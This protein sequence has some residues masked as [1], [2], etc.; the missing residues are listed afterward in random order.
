MTDSDKAIL[1]QYKVDARKFTTCVDITDWRRIP[2]ANGV[3]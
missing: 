2:V 1:N 3:C